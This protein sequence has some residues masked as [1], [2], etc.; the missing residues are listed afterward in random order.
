MGK[1]THT[2]NEN[3]I[4]VIMSIDELLMSC[5]TMKE[6]VCM[7]YSFAGQVAA[8]KVAN[9]RLAPELQKIKRFKIER[10]DDQIVVTMDDFDPST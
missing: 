8:E 10:I 5:A 7:G 3:R 1:I 6:G 2:P 4:V 9:S